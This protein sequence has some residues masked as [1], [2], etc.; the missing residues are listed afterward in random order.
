M[1]LWFKTLPVELKALPLLRIQAL[2]GVR[3]SKA[4]FKSHLRV[5]AGSKKTELHLDSGSIFRA[6]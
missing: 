6:G 4:E 2:V 5:K 3:N 1:S